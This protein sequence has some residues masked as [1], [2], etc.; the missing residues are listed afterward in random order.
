M[1]RFGEGETGGL[2]GFEDGLEREALRDAKVAVDR[3]TIK[4]VSIAKRILT[5]QRTGRTY[6][7]SRTGAL[8]T[9]SA[10][11]E[12]PA[13]LSGR[14]R[15]SIGREPAKVSGR[16]VEGRWG[17]NVEYAARH[18]FGGRNPDGSRYAARPWA[19]PTEQ[20]LGPEI[21]DEVRRLDR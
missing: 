8:H 1:I 2:D 3:L 17:T 4:A 13:V 19:R 6:R 5:G 20:E 11:G 10:P 9:A 15:N 7:V 12:A 14:L 21:D 18:E 16:E